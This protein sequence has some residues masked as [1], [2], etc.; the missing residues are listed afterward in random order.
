ML[1]PRCPLIHPTLWEAG[2]PQTENTHLSKEAADWCAI[3]TRDLHNRTDGTSGSHGVGFHRHQ[4]DSPE[5]QGPA[6]GR[7]GRCDR[8]RGGPGRWARGRQ[9]P[10]RWGPFHT[11]CQASEK[12][13]EKVTRNKRWSR[14]QPL[15]KIS[16]AHSLG[17]SRQIPSW[18]CPLFLMFCSRPRPWDN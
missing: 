16:H 12:E 14:F 2:D 9:S 1:Y 17:E 8:M 11:D 18:T 13:S 10:P 3:L 6:S 15:L 7:T 5:A 4:A